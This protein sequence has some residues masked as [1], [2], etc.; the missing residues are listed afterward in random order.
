MKDL[1]PTLR[2][3]I[4]M[5]K[6]SDIAAASVCLQS[7]ETTIAGFEPVKSFSDEK[8]AKCEASSVGQKKVL[9]V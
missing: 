9:N 4:S 7:L 5:S 2:F 6:G 3:E 1:T 8:V